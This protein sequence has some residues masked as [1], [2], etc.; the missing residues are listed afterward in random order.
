MSLTLQLTTTFPPPRLL[1]GWQLS[2]ERMDPSLSPDD[3]SQVVGAYASDDS[4]LEAIAQ[5]L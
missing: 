3:Q 2:S 4:G 1:A 5:L